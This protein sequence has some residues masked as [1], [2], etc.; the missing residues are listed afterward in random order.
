MREPSFWWRRS[1]LAARL[2]QPAGAIYGAVA[3]RRLQ[4]AG[5]RAGIPVICIG[6][7][8]LGGAGKTPTAIAVAR[9]LAAM[10]EKPFLLSRGYGGVLAGPLLVDTAVHKAAE[11]G[12]EP[13]LLARAAPTIVA[14]DRVAGAALARRSGASVIVMDD[15]LQN[16]SLV[17]DFT[18]AVIDGRR[19]IGNAR[20]FPAGPLRAPLSA[21]L[22]CLDAVLFIDRALPKIGDFELSKPSWRGQ[23]QPDTRAVEALQGRKLL[24][25][26]GIADPEKFYRTLRAAGLDAVGHVS[27]PDHHEFT[28]AD[29]GKLLARCDRED[30]TPVTTEKDFVRLS[31]HGGAG[32]KLAERTRVLPVT[33]VLDDETGLRQM[34]RQRM[35]RA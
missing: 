9:I 10:G 11:V 26:A 32:A 17:K 22:P 24:A 27:F 16:P 3:S 31:A 35:A 4:Q 2:L 23:L 21:Q 28:A 29:A 7:L 20:V 12:D 5:A 19:G 8:T 34:L 6:N 15:G 30:L 14:R 25:F 33:L 13:L 18:I 1:G